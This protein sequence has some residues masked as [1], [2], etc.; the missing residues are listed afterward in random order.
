[1]IWEADVAKAKGQDVEAAR[2][3]LGP[4]AIAFAP[5]A[6]TRLSTPQAN[7]ATRKNAPNVA[8]K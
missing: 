8:R 6:G 2:K 5:V 4:T 7:P 3:L 1:V